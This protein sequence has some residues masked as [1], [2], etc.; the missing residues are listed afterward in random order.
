MLGVVTQLLTQEGHLDYSRY[1]RPWQK[2]MINAKCR[3]S[4]RIGDRELLRYG[5]FVEEP[6]W[7]L[8]ATKRGAWTGSHFVPPSSASFHRAYKSI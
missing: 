5:G 1:C 4:E 7:Q 2:S 3:K 6:D 8:C